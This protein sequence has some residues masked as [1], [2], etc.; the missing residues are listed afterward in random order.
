[1]KWSSGKK[2]NLF[3][4]KLYCYY[5]YGSTALCWALAAFSVSWSYAQSVGPLGRG[6]SPSQGRYLHTGQHEPRMNAHNI[7]IHALSGI[8]T[9]DLSVR[10][11]EDSSCLRPRGHCD[12]LLWT[13]LYKTVTGVHIPVITLQTKNFRSVICCYG[14]VGIPQETGARLALEVCREYFMKLLHICPALMW[15]SWTVNH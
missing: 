2:F 9:H 13:Y 6:I 7:D 8:R 14:Y 1:M 5:Y 3:C 12:R 11:S 10:A 15:P 4:Y